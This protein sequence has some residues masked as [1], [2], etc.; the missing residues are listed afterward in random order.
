[1]VYLDL[2]ACNCQ[3][4]IDRVRAT[5]RYK[6]FNVSTPS[7]VNGNSPPMARNFISRARKRVREGDTYHCVDG[8]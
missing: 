5:V 7:K 8:S 2:V 4:I 1:M 6:I 3:C